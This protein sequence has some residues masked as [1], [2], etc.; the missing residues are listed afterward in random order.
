MAVERVERRLRKVA[1]ALDAAGVPYA[2]IGGN[3]VAA[4][5]ARIDPAATRT[6]IDVDLLVNRADDDRI[7][8]VMDGLGFQRKDLRRIVM[9]IDPDE[10]SPRAGVHL[11]WAEQFIRPS[12]ATAAPSLDESVEDPQGFRV[13]DLP[14]LVRMKLTSYR[15]LDRVHLSDLIE[16]GLIDERV[17][18]SLPAEL[19]A[20]LDQVRQQR[21]KDQL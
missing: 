21:A 3:A 15:D 20:R 11:V 1:A 12:Y 13:L 2:V 6:T 5:I 4:W 19:R 14:A 16:V 18:A 8:D 9:Y 7:A 17:E 10:P